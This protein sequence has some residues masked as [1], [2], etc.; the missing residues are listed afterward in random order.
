MHPEVQ[1]FFDEET[2][3]VSYVV[4]EVAAEGGPRACAIID[5]VLDFDAKSGRTTTQ[6]ADKIIAYVTER[7]LTVEWI[8][9][10]HIHADHLT[11]APYLK[12]KL[13]G[14]TAIG[15][16]AV[17]VQRTF[18]EIF[19]CGDDF[20]P[21]GSQFDCLLKDAD[22]LALGSMSIRVLHT[23]GHTPAC[24]T[25][26]IGDSAFVGDT[27]FMPDFGTARVD[28]P[29][30]D[31]GTL[32]RSIRKILSLPADTKLF[33]CHDYAPGGRDYLWETTVAKQRAENIH[34]QD[35]IEESDFA[36]MRREKDKTLSMPNLLLPAVQVNIRAGEFPAPEDNGVRYL[37]IP[38][39]RL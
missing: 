34:V 17:A 36:N 13:G 2:F 24:M 26:L 15:A 18:K 11:A 31:A 6:S 19:N 21:D 32:F 9:E 14:R 8:L 28:F 20:T 37:K 16:E 35:G 39:D 1:A 30:G 7:K 27:L 3:T 38:L 25:Y 29:G 4:S 22:S 5:S 12:S 33:L 10:T 23:P